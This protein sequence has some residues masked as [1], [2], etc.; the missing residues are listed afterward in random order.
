MVEFGR[1]IRVIEERGYGFI[2]A[3]GDPSNWIFFHYANLAG[4]V[5]PKVGVRVSFV[6]TS[7]ER[8][9]R[10]VCVGAESEA[11]AA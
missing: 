5:T 3:D 11:E 9:P 10:A 8:G 1:F 4:D 6:R 2:E 7:T